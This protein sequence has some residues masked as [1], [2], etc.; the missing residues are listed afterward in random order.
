DDDCRGHR[1]RRSG[2]A[3][4]HVFLQWAGRAA[5]GADGVQESVLGGQAAVRGLAGVDAFWRNQNGAFRREDE[6]GQEEGSQ[7]GADE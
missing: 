2:R 1:R 5:Y 7:A 4:A 6:G 3:G